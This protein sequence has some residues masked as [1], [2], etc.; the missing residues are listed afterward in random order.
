MCPQVRGSVMSAAIRDIGF[1]GDDR[2][3]AVSSSHGTTHVFALHPTGGAV[4]ATTHSPAA[5][6]PPRCAAGPAEPADGDGGSQV[7][8][9]RADALIRSA[10]S[11]PP[12]FSLSLSL[13]ST[14]HTLF[15]FTAELH[16]TGLYLR[17]V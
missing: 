3:V 1:S 15:L 8:S 2:W 12:S 17:P 13:C 9:L 14:R 4:D 10:R 5:L 6:P 7:L 11:S 16:S